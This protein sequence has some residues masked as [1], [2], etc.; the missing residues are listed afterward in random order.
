MGNG[1]QIYT[2]LVEKIES[3]YDVSIR[4]AMDVWN[5]ILAF[6]RH[7]Q[8]FIVSPRGDQA[9]AAQYF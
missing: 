3:L 2:S 1:I 8:S 5:F 6:L 7:L 4:N 9:L